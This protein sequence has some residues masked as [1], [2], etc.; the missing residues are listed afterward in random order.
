MMQLR[1]LPSPL[2]SPHARFGCRFS[3]PTSD[4]PSSRSDSRPLR[5]GP[6]PGILRAYQ[7]SFSSSSSPSNS[8]SA[9]ALDPA[10][11]LLLSLRRARRHDAR[12]LVASSRS[13]SP[14][15]SLARFFALVLAVRSPHA[16]STF[17]FVIAV[18][19][20]RIRLAHLR[21]FR[22]RGARPKLRDMGSRPCDPLV[23]PA[24]H[25]VSCLPSA[26]PCHP[27]R[28]Q[29]R[30]QTA[31]QA[32][33]A[34]RPAHRARTAPRLI[35][36][37][38]QLGPRRRRRLRGRCVH[39]PGIHLRVLCIALA[40]A[41]LTS[42]VLVSTLQSL[43]RQLR[44]RTLSSARRQP[45]A[46]PMHPSA[47]KRIST[48]ARLLPSDTLQPARPITIS[49]RIILRRLPDRLAPPRIQQANLMLRLSAPTRTSA[50]Q[51]R[52]RCS[53]VTSNVNMHS[54]IG[55]NVRHCHY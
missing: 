18:V 55:R 17:I 51:F 2:S 11:D 9:V 49:S 38:L 23:S 52:L 5:S 43:P 47:T 14:A 40:R 16:H 19:G 46:S 29:L 36:R 30:P 53:P 31:S 34:T 54:A 22:T 21:G 37:Q 25:S 45:L 8:C 27:N 7:I 41:V 1:S 50:S 28:L 26:R 6:C 32:P 13:S 20:R 42:T 12:P 4:G 24:R 44:F 3:P 15:R 35:P 33:I 48:V 39:V 10:A